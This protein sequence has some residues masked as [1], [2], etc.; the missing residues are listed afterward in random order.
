[1]KNRVIISVM[2]GG[3]AL[4]LGGCTTGNIATQTALYDDVYNSEV[5]ARALTFTPRPAANA[6]NHSYDY[7]TDNYAYEEEAAPRLD[8]ENRNDYNWRDHYYNNNLAFDPFFDPAFSMGSM[9]WNNWG[10]NSWNRPGFGFN[11]G[12]NNWGWNN[13]NLGWNNW[14]WNNWGWNNWAYNPWYSPL[15]S[16]YWGIYSFNNPWGGGWIGNGGLWGGGGFFPGGGV[17]TRP[18]SPRPSR[19][20]VATRPID[21]DGSSV[22][23]IP[24]PTGPVST[25]RPG[26][27]SRPTRDSYGDYSRPATSSTRP[28]SSGSSSRPSGNSRPTRSE[29]QESRPSRTESSR[30]SRTERPS[31][32]PSPSYSPPSNS[33]SGS[34]RGS[35][36]GSSS[37]GGRPSR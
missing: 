33:G 4:I 32:S 36:G 31:Y 16:P 10:W 25:S 6:N 8:I 12:W 24:R 37:G 23:R 30:P 2:S 18:N 21:A 27:S 22:S 13:W 26:T 35:S 11:L 15:G 9:G 34:S 7:S 29:A 1:M 17:I 19:G 5:E 20:S 3:I 14:G 28:S